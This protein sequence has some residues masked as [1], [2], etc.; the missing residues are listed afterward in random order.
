[1][2][3]KTKKEIKKFLRSYLRDVMFGDGLEDDYICDGINYIGLNNMT[4]DELIQEMELCGFE[5]PDEEEYQLLAKAKSE[6]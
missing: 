2:K 4:D 1:M 3:N 5:D 6:P